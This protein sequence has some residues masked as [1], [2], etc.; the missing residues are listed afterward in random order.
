MPHGKNPFDTSI[1]REPRI[2]EDDGPPPTPR[3]AR[4]VPPGFGTVDPSRRAWGSH[5]INVDLL[6]MPS[7]S[8]LDPCLPPKS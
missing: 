7:K 2:V 5:R 3:R 1:L 4:G 8:I 6:P